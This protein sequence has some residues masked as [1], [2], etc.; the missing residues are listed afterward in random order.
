MPNRRIRSGCCARAA[1]GHV[2]AEPTTTL[3]KSRRRITAP[4]FQEHADT[5]RLHQGITTG[6]MG[7]GVSLHGSNP[8]PAMSA[9][10]QKRTSDR[11]LLMSALPPKADIA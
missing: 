2:T 5:D 11:R 6:E 7:S 8:E 3:L 10:G 9:L 4:R 1:S